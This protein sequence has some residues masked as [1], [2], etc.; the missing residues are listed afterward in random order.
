MWTYCQ[1]SGALT[2]DGAMAGVGYSGA[3]PLGKNNPSMQD[4]RDVGPIPQGLYTVG[5]P[6]DTEAHG[7]HVMR[8]TPDST[9]QMFGR[10]GFLIHGDSIARP[11]FASEGCIIMARDVRNA[12]SS[13]T[14][15]RLTVTASL[16]DDHDHARASDDG[17]PHPPEPVS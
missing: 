14:D 17:M 1:A 9:N 3:P 16:P 2:H 12:V 4:T 6:F 11:G 7:P 5:D 15:K 8:L 13:S 10:S